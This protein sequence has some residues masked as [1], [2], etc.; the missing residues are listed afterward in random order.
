MFLF[1]FFF[2]CKRQEKRQAALGQEGAEIPEARDF[3]GLRLPGVH[4]AA[5]AEGPIVTYNNNN[6]KHT[7]QSTQ[8]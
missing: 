4:G 3:R 5:A 7:K 6:T 1:K 8:Y 2:I